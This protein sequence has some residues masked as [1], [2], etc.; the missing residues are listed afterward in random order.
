M[1]FVA[2]LLMCLPLVAEAQI[3]A[4]TSEGPAARVLP[5]VIQSMDADEYAAWAAWNNTLAQKY[6]AQFNGQEARY[7]KGWSTTTN[8]TSLRA[9]GRRYNG[10][11]MSQLT[12][13]FQVEAPHLT[14]AAVVYNPFCKAP[15]GEAAP[16]WDNLFC[17]YNGEI[18]SV[19]DVARTLMVPIPKEALYE[20]LLQPFRYTKV[21]RTPLQ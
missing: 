4:S 10:F 1:R 9:A 14:K 12:V 7:Y 18:K 13:P 8:G 16:D 21:E 11:N 5:K 20:Q 19:N 2:F 6:V 3:I 17:I 15:S